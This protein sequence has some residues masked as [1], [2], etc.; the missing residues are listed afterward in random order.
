MTLDSGGHGHQREEVDRIETAIE[1]CIRLAER[2][3]PESVRREFEAWLAVHPENAR[4]FDRVASTWQSFGVQQLDPELL[5]MRRDALDRFHNAHA[6][7]WTRHAQRR[8]VSGI[9]AAV[10][11]VAILVSFW[12]GFMPQG[13]ETTLGERRTVVL[14]DGSSISLDSQTRVEV[15]YSGSKR[16]LRLARG[17]AKFSV[18]HDPLRPFTVEAANRKVVA[19]GTEFS[20]ELFTSQVQVILYEGSVEVLRE[21]AAG[22]QESRRTQLKPGR[23]LIASIDGEAIELRN[24]DATASLAWE[25]GQI[26]FDD[27]TLETAVERMNRYSTAILQVGDAAAGRIRISGTFAAGDIDAFVEGVTGVFPVRAT[28]TDGRVV[29]VSGTSP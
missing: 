21:T 9:A 3:V 10:A 16:E 6:S 18:A 2:S 27:E 28:G 4:A 1:W 26:S 14:E 23:A 7:K 25:A 20:V 8:T 22:R 15:R 19:T 17:R 5:A 12:V 11:L 24:V 13:Y 29:F